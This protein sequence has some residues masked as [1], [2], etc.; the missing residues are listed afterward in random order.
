MF[1][2]EYKPCECCGKLVDCGEYGDEREGFDNYILTAYDK[3]I[4]HT[5]AE[6]WIAEEES[7]PLHDEPYEGGARI[8]L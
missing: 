3:M 1:E 8:W 4:C 5:C 7:Y 2:V 6:D